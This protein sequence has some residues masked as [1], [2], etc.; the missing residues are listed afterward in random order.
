MSSRAALGFLDLPEDVILLILTDYCDVQSVIRISR[1]S[2]YLHRVAFLHDV[3]LSLVT[4]LVQRRI[5]DVRRGKGQNLQELSTDQ[6]I[7]KVKRTLRG[8]E[9]WSDRSDAAPN[10]SSSPS[11]N[12]SVLRQTVR[13]VKNLAKKLVPGRTVIMTALSPSRIFAPGAQ[14]IVIDSHLGT[15]PLLAWERRVMLLP[16]GEYVLFQ[17]S[18]RLECWKISQDQVIWTHACAMRDASVRNF[19]A[20]I[21]EDDRVV[22]LTCQNTW[23]TRQ[24]FVEITILDLKTGNSDLVLV[25]RAPDFADYH[26]CSLCGSIA[27]V[28]LTRKLFLV[29]WRTHS[30][31]VVKHSSNGP[32][33]SCRMALIP[34]YIVFPRWSAPDN[35]LVASVCPIAAFDALWVPVDSIQEPSHYTVSLDDLPS[36]PADDIPLKDRI[37]DVS[38]NTRMRFW[39]YESPI[40]RGV[41]RVWA[42]L[43]MGNRS[44][45]QLCAYELTAGPSGASWKWLP[46]LEAIGDPIGVL[47]SGRFVD[48]SREIRPPGQLEGDATNSVITLDLPWS[49][50]RPHV[51]PYSGTVACI[52]E[53]GEVNIIYYD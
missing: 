10:H 23:D 1:T 4:K 19:A 29:N 40:S 44:R 43:S 28:D 48:E 21:I 32:S 34:H 3:W 41:F 26:S 12:Q 18:G 50:S 49:G 46:T 11:P 33:F 45:G 27:A 2:K 47:Y 51:S 24:N 7:A 22:I 31:V 14:R 20:D 36:I 15:G 37:G 53:E 35:H 16:G 13:R 38:P 25:S 6:L 17:A 39:V 30:H 52:T 42:H 8:P 5:I 9:T